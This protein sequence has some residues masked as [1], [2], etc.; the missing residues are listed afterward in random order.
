MNAW[1]LAGGRCAHAAVISL[2]LVAASSAQAQA[3]SQVHYQALT[4]RSTISVAAPTIVPN[5]S[6]PRT[7]YFAYN[8]TRSYGVGDFNGDGL[9]DILVAPTYHSNLPERSIEI[10]GNQGNGTFRDITSERIRGAPVSTGQVNLVVVADFNEDGRPDVFLVDQGLEINQPLFPGHRL[11][12]LLSDADG[13]LSDASAQISP[14]EVAFNHS[15]DV[16]DIDGDGHLDIVV[17][18]L[19]V[20][21][22]HEADGTLIFRGDGKGNFSALTTALPNELAYIPWSAVNYA[23]NRQNQGCSTAADLDGDGRTDLIT[24]TYSYSD[25]LTGLRTVRFHQ[26][27]LDGEFVER[28]RFEVPAA[29]RDVGYAAALRQ[30]ANDG[31]GCA[32]ITTADLFGN[33]RRDVVVLW[34]GAGKSYI[35][36]LR[37]DGNFTF[38]DSTIPSIGTYA[39]TRPDGPLANY[40]L[41]D[42]NGDGAVDIVGRSY[43]ETAERLT[44]GGTIFLNNGRGEFSR[45]VPASDVG[46]M[47]VNQLATVTG[48]EACSSMP[49]VI[50]V[51]NDGRRD[52]AFV[53]FGAVAQTLPPIQVSAVEVGVLLARSTFAVKQVVEYYNSMLDHYFITWVPEEIAALDSGS[54]RGWV[55][56]RRAFKTFAVPQPGTSPVCRFY[57]PPGLGDSHFF[58]RSAAECQ[59]TGQRN[60]AFVLEHGAFMQMNLPTAGVCPVN[61]VAIYRVFSNRADANH[62]YMLERAIRSQMSGQGWLVEGDGPDA[63]VMCAPQ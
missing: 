18:R 43:G 62:R 24:G 40:L 23:K 52:I 5:P 51:D 35:E 42:V 59:S 12:L 47:S 60:A 21:G 19:G 44:E 15:G 28:S 9:P 20:P 34:E 3:P 50:D 32:S 49:L 31:L 25:N 56:T 8:H 7:Y 57:I 41:T 48:C 27:Q 37:N 10:W 33:G 11:G 26:Q 38:V 55:R 39:T 1:N 2:C 4:S 16:A 58:G 29:I 36:V 53:N 17:T 45:W 22:L 30:G 14:N 13:R 6:V 46:P 63:V 54:I 61:T